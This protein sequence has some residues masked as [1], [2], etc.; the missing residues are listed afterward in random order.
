MNVSCNE[1]NCKLS[2]PPWF[3]EMHASKQVFQPF[4]C[5]ST[6]VF[7]TLLVFVAM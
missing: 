7:L 4:G 2:T 1:K 6:V 5:T 3:A